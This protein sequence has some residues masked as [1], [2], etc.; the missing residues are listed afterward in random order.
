MKVILLVVLSFVRI[1]LLSLGQAGT[2]IHGKNVKC[3]GV[4]NICTAVQLSQEKCVFY[5]SRRSRSLNFAWMSEKKVPLFFNFKGTSFS[6]CFLFEK[7]L[8]A[9]RKSPVLSMS[10]SFL[11]LS[12]R[13]WRETLVEQSHT[14]CQTY[15]GW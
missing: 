5:R 9:R 10:L 11:S 15:Q 8:H 14:Y 1:R 2:R 13:I 6:V 12:L 4:Q 3:T 7:V